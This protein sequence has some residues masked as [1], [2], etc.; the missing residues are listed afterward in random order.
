MEANHNNK[1]MTTTLISELNSDYP[2]AQAGLAVLLGRGVLS[3]AEIDEVLALKNTLIISD[4]LEQY[5]HFSKENFL[6]INKYIVR[7]LSNRNRLFVSDL[8]ECADDWNMELPYMKCVKCLSKF[9]GDHTFVQ[10]AMLD[11]VFNN[12][13][14][15][16]LDEIT[17]ALDGILSNSECN[18][19]VQ[20]KAAFYIFRITHKRKYLDDLLDLVVN[21]DDNKTLMRNILS[22]KFNGSE[23]FEY[24]DLLM[25]VL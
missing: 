18:Q 20:V 8:V 23:Y 10:L 6:T 5:R 21:G 19:S 24:H 12:L 13:K 9:K 14:M 2:V 4:F 3:A 16:Y 15:S 1:P 7:N 25:S 11:Y 17:S 22:K